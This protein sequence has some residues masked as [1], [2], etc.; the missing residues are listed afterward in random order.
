MKRYYVNMDDVTTVKAWN[1]FRRWQAERKERL[2]TK[3]YSYVV[4]NVKPDI[5]RLNANRTETTITWIGHSTFLLQ[6][7]GLNIVT[8]PVWAARMATQARLAPPGIPIEEMPPVDV[9][10]ISH[11]HYDH[12]HIRSLR[13]LVGPNT[14]LIVPDGLL[15]KL[16]RKGFSIIHELAWWE[17]ITVADRVKISFVPAQ[18]WTRR[19]L[20]DMNRSHWGGY[21]LEHVAQAKKTSRGSDS[22]STLTGGGSPANSIESGDRR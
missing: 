20:T 11:S 2:K 10:L 17:H 13:R 21:V 7:G 6:I 9:V 1:Q 12:L 19:T 15:S 5:A 22:S 14:M 18:H 4:P 3:D 8:D 16:R